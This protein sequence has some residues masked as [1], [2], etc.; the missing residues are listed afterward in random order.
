M[1][2]MAK[3]L[4]TVSGYVHCTTSNKVTV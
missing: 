1:T 2:T 3:Q 4:K